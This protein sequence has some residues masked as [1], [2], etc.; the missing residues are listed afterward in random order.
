MPKSTAR[1][2]TW[3]IMLP[4]SV[5]YLLTV[6]D[7]RRGGVWAKLFPLTFIMSV[8]WLGGLSYVMVWMVTI[9]GE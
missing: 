1:K 3:V 7:C 2:I 4:A 9:V 5:L 8:T 6:P